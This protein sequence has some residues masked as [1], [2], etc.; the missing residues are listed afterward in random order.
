MAIPSRVLGS[1]LSQLSTVSICGDG[2]DEISAAGTS[3][4][5]AT[6]LTFVYNSIDTVPS[7]SGV[8]L[9]P[10]EEGEVIFVVNSGANTLKVYPYES[11]T[12]INQTT[13][14]TVN[15]DHTSIFFAVTPTI[16][17]SINGTKT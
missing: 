12:T 15:K 3:R 9:P 6:Q 2:K 4:S 8:L 7:G 13:S 5:D 10:T 11:T 17:Y 14:A 1:G 16:W